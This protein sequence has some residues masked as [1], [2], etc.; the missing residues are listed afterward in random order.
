MSKIVPPPIV[1]TT[2]TETMKQVLAWT[3]EQCVAAMQSLIAMPG[4]T[5]LVAIL[6]S[7]EIA[8]ARQALESGE[9]KTL[10][11]VENLQYKISVAKAMLAIPESIIKAGELRQLSDVMQ[12]DQDLDPYE[13]IQDEIKPGV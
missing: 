7:Q 2:P 10:A 1:V 9:H 4:W 12:Q 8:T 6:G 11:E 13:Q 3:P 5:L